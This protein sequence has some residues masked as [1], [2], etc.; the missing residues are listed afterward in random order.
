MMYGVVNLRREAYCTKNRNLMQ[1]STFFTEAIWGHQVILD[2]RMLINLGVNDLK[3]CTNF[4]TVA[5]VIVSSLSLPAFANSLPLQTGIYHGG[6]SRYIQIAVKDERLCF[7]GYSGRGETVASITPD[8]SLKGFYR[9][10]GWTDTVLYQ[11]DLKTL[12]FGSTNNLLPY[13]A[14]YNLSQDI[15]DSLQ[16]CLESD[17]PFEQRFDARGRLIR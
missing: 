12:L 17:V 13:E 9:I 6:G 16:Q 14:D 1:Q 7:H 4:M 10:N 3:I 11:Q 15:S 2:S 5:V 8:P